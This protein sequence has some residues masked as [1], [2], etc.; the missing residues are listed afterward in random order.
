M[1]DEAHDSWEALGGRTCYSRTA[2]DVLELRGADARRFLNSQVTCDVKSLADGAEAPGFFVGP[3]GK[4][5]ADVVVQATGGAFRLILPAGQGGAI[6]ARLRKYL[7]AD[8][9]EI[10]ALAL[11]ALE[12]HGAGLPWRLYDAETFDALSAELAAAGT[13]IVG[14]EVAEQARIL[15]GRP[16][17]G[18]DFGTDN[19]PQETGREDAISYTKGCYLGQ[20]VVARIHYRGGVQRQL[21]GLRLEARVAVP[22][23]LRSDGQ[24]VGRLTSLAPWPQDGA[25]RG[26][27]IVHKKAEPGSTLEVA[28][29]AGESIEAVLEEP[30]FRPR[31]A[32]PG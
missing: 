10:A 14:P 20:E 30:V 9:V 16:R 15:A 28:T 27:G 4:I 1:S 7:I 17:F 5:E 32:Q 26:L 25:W 29:E 19:F 13:P 21:R 24:E 18:V 3:K 22:A 6:E 11:A 8:R 23:A 2:A 31:P 12:P